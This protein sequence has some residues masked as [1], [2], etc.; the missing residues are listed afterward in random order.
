ADGG[1]TEYTPWISAVTS[2]TLLGYS[3]ILLW[4]VLRKRRIAQTVVAITS[5]ALAVFATWWWSAWSGKFLA[6]MGC[7]IAIFGLFGGFWIFAAKRGWS[8][9]RSGH[10]SS[11][12]KRIGLA[13]LFGGLVLI[14]DIALTV[15]LST[16]LLSTWNFD[17]GPPSI[18]L[19]PLSANHSL[20]I[21]KV[22]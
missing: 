2:L 5:A 11:L 8:A 3:P 7:W 15:F 18:L 13:L 20:F 14:A 1:T 17:C 6:N 10:Q 4:L 21:A 12:Q 19:H 16:R 9:V 22:V